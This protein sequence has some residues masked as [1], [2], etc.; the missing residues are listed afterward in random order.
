MS[1]KIKDVVKKTYT[2][3]AKV[4]L[5]AG[6]GPACCSPIQD[7]MNDNWSMSESYAEMDGYQEDADYALGCGLPTRDAKIKEGDTVLD[8]GSGAGNDVFVAR[9]VVG[10]MGKVI[11]VDMTEAM[12][13]KANQN[14]EKLG[15]SNVEFKLGEIEDLPIEDNSIDVVVSNCV[16]NLVPSK[17]K[18]YQE[19]YRVL[20]PNGHFNMSD[21]VLLGDLPKGIKEAA[22]L[23]AG[24]I[25]GALEKEA[26]LKVIKDA[27]FKNITITKERAIDVPDHVFLQYVSPAELEEFKSSSNA[28]ISLGVFAKK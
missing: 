9:S 27:G 3:V 10:E 15:F 7:V 24:C 25:S 21:I 28:I 11:G 2:E 17:E 13:A 18:A 6:C 16:M 22:Q 26:Y 23:Y 14:K 5:G 8:L 1:Q 4:G 12:I 19:T 20:K